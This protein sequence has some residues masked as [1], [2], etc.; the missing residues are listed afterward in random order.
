MQLAAE[1]R[2]GTTLGG[3]LD[4]TGG[5]GPGF[6]F[7][8][9]ALSFCILCWHSVDV[10]YGDKAGETIWATP[11]GPFGAI[12]LP[13]FFAL[14]GF[15]VMGSAIRVKSL[16]TFLSFR[17]LRILPALSIEVCFSAVL[18]GGAVTTLPTHLY[19]H[20]HGFLRYF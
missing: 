7:L 8:R 2:D 1:E 16:T 6:N 3:V 15:L 11:L 19:F 14:S 5:I 9:I 10:S 4:R 18:I 17:I 13:A 20:S 12:L